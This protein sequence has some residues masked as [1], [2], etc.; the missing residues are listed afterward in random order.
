[1]KAYKVEL[2]IIDFDE[3]GD[4]IPFFIENERY[5][6]D[7]LQPSVMK[8]EC[9][10]IGEWSDDHPLNQRISCKEEYQRL[11]KGEDVNAR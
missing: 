9:R 6:N 10:E 7:C 3:V 2:L 11:F 5:P 1:M 4:Q 8:V